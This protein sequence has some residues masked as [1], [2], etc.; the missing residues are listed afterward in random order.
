[1]TISVPWRVTVAIAALLGSTFLTGPL[2]AAR[3]DSTAPI[4]LAQ[5]APQKAEAAVEQLVTNLHAALKIT[6]AEESKWNN[7]AQ[8]VRENVVN[9]QKLA[10]GGIPQNMTAVENLNAYEK[11]TRAHAERLKNLISSFEIL[12]NSMPDD[13]KKNADQV[14]QTFGHAGVSCARPGSSIA[15]LQC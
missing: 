8:A 3:A 14:F 5:T 11:F 12:Y 7:V 4:Q 2:T 15:A 10:M 6:P 13:Q 9:A 1:M